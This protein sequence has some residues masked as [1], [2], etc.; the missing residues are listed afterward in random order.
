M[1]LRD[2]LTYYQDI[3]KG[4]SIV[5]NMRLAVCALARNCEKK[6]VGNLIRLR[7]LQKECAELRIYV[8]ENDSIDNT[9]AVLEKYTHNSD[10]RVQLYDSA[11]C[12]E[13]HH[14]FVDKV[15]TNNNLDALMHSNDRL[16]TEN[17]MKRMALLRDGLLYAVKKDAFS[18]HVLVQIDLD[19]HWFDVKGIVH[20]FAHYDVWDAMNANGRMFTFC[21]YALSYNLF[22][23]AYAFLPH[24][25]AFIERFIPHVHNQYVYAPLSKGQPL[26]PVYSAFGGMN[27][28]KYPLIANESYYKIGEACDFECCEHVSWY[29]HLR[30]KYSTRVYINPSL[31]VHYNSFWK[32]LVYAIGVK[33]IRYK[34]LLWKYLIK[35]LHI[36]FLPLIFMLKLMREPNKKKA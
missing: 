3:Q 15:R 23:D 33:K 32:T 29:K 22:F 30:E 7:D 4:K 17:R 35:T 24:N 1:T 36:F 28:Q 25:T 20:S 5:R 11:I 19:V 6:I 14:H 2:T 34:G 31:V 13:A 21:Q 27:L 10:M 8:I 9:R 18:P 16:L 12:K 26:Y